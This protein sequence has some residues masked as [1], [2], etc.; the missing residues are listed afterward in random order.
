M[1][2]TGGAILPR[3]P[4]FIASV[5]LTVRMAPV[6]QPRRSG[7]RCA[8]V[9]PGSSK[10]GVLFP[11]LSVTWLKDRVRQR[12]AL[13]SDPSLRGYETSSLIDHFCDLAGSADLFDDFVD[14]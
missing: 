7:A 10:I 6:A 13:R 4:R 14:R 2:L 8:V 1:I 9:P 3:E 12:E 5:A 11:R